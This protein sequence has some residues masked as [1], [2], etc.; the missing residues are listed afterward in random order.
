MGKHGKPSAK[1]VYPNV[2]T[3]STTIPARATTPPAAKAAWGEALAWFGKY[4]LENLTMSDV[5][6]EGGNM[7]QSNGCKGFACTHPSC[8]L[9]AKRHAVD[10]GRRDFLIDAPAEPTQ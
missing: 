3:L 8:G 6:R 7:A 10:F 1:N 5:K 9:A 4:L 2:T